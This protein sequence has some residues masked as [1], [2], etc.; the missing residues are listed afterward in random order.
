MKFMYF[1]LSMILLSSCNHKKEDKK[2]KQKENITKNIAL[3]DILVSSKNFAESRLN[4]K[5]LTTIKDNVLRIW[6]FPGG[7]GG[8]VELYEINIDKQELI[9]YSCLSHDLSKQE[10]ERETQNLSEI[11]FVKKIQ[12][13]K[14]LLK[15]SEL[16]TLNSFLKIENSSHYCEMKPGCRDVYLLEYKKNEIIKTFEIDSNIKECD[17]KKLRTIKYLYSLIEKMAEKYGH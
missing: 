14:L 15:F 11:E 16:T 7:G 13:K 2:L 8:F 6:R 3:Y 5:A 10:I 1:F 12:N 9:Q 17:S 4:L